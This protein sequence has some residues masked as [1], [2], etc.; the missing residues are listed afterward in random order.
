MSSVVSADSW[1]ARTVRR[2]IRYPADRTVSP[3]RRLRFRFIARVTDARR[4]L[5]GFN[6]VR[7]TNPTCRGRPCLSVI[8]QSGAIGFG[9]ARRRWSTPAPWP[10]RCR[11]ATGRIFGERATGRRFFRR[12][13]PGIRQRFDGVGGD[14][15][16]EIPQA[17]GPGW[18]ARRLGTN[19]GWSDNGRRDAAV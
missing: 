2:C 3:P 17:D 15:R 7:A 6:A 10:V 11:V 1:G 12:I 13:Q 14:S 8:D 9:R 4:R 19:W 5:H 16:G 18:G